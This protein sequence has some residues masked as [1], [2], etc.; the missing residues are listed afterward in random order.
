MVSA[1]QF[2]C[3]KLA[4]SIT[5]FNSHRKFT[6]QVKAKSPQKK[7]NQF[8]GVESHLHEEWSKIPPKWCEDLVKSFQN[9][10][11]LPWQVMAW[12]PNINKQSWARPFFWHLRPRPCGFSLWG[13]GRAAAR[14]A[15]YSKQTWWQSSA[16][17]RVSPWRLPHCHG[18]FSSG[19]QGCCE[20]GG[21]WS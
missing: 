6:A 12:P 21:Q 16:H 17:S 2:E 10:W 18:R 8:C 7:T 11:L 1:I 5:R 3:I 13:G 15:Q 19:Q 9:E 20:D 4:K 14:L